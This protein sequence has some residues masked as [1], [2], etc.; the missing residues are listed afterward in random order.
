MSFV[1]RS[2][3]DIGSR[4]GAFIKG[5]TTRVYNFKSFDEAENF[6]TMVKN[7]GTDA[8]IVGNRVVVNLEGMSPAARKNLEEVKSAFKSDMLYDGGNV[9]G[10]GVSWKK[11]LVVTGGVV[12]AIVLIDPSTGAAIGSRIA[13]TATQLVEPFIPSMLSV[14]I[15]CCLLLSSA[16]AAIGIMQRVG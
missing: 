8:A 3:G 12:V 7:L 14:M 15:P 11:V 5:S 10:G 2:L 9:S 13:G 6:T 4:A 16:L 1:K